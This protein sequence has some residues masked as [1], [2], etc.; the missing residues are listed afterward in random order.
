MKRSKV[1]HIEFFF[2]I[3]IASHD[4]LNI[5]RSSNLAS[6]IAGE[7][8]LSLLTI[9]HPL[10]LHRQPSASVLHLNSLQVILDDIN[11]NQPFFHIPNYSHLHQVDDDKFI[12]DI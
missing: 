3:R 5:P 11:R 7:G 12:S 9:T 1:N 8:H 10:L 6:P 4:L 2:T